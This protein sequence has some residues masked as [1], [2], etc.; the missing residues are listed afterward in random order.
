MNRSAFFLGL[1]ACLGCSKP[2]L[3]V[4]HTLRPLSP[5]A[6]KSAPSE[7]P[8]A[9]EIMPIRL[10]ES[11]QRPQL[12]R[13]TGPG[14]MSLWEAHRWANGLDKDIQRILVENLSLLAP[15]SSVVPYPQG[16]R[17]KAAH[18]LEVEVQR[19]AGQPN[20]TLTLQ[21]TWMLTPL[22]GGPAL[23]F[24]RV[25]LQAPVQGPDAEAM[26]AAHNRVLEDLSRDIAAELGALNL[27]EKP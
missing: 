4:L 15:T 19:L 3:E 25:T 21:A 13:E 5:D 20:G 6:A 23:R 7:I 16:E 2:N 1:I 26:V 18:R 9:L 24:R 11:V 22:Q 27:K 12:V 14:T 8:L 17:V 10:P